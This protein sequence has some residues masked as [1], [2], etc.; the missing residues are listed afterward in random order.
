M[1]KS[2]TTMGATV[3]TLFWQIICRK[4][5]ISLYSAKY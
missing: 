5:Q 2:K 3:P 1:E 4:Q